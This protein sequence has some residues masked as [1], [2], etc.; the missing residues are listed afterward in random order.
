MINRSKVKASYLILLLKTRR[1]IPISSK[2]IAMI[3]NKMTLPI[4]NCLSIPIHWQ[5]ERHGNQKKNIEDGKWT[6]CAH[7]KTQ[8]AICVRIKVCCTSRE[9]HKISMWGRMM[10]LRQAT[11][12]K[13]KK[14]ESSRL[15]WLISR[16]NKAI[17]TICM[18]LPQV[19]I[20]K[21]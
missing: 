11:K 21:V 4:Y 13:V 2:S 1:P 3:Q 9:S 19:G 14:N 12:I 20:N 8:H 10:T 7:G 15:L 5:T 17:D 6:A 18:S 16:V